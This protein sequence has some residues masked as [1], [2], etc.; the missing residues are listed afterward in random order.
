MCFRKTGRRFWLHRSKGG[1]VY[2]YRQYMCSTYRS[3]GKHVCTSNAVDQGALLRTIIRLLQQ[4]VLGAGQNRDELRRRV[5]D[6]LR[7]RQT[8]DPAE[9][10]ALEAKA[11]ESRPLELLY[12]WIISAYIFRGYREGLRES[13]R[14]WM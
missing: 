1:K 9:A 14:V 2:T 3:Q 5:L 11:P 7:P 6:T 4:C 12:R 8:A 13:A 10:K